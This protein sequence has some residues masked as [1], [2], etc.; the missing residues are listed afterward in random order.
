MGG[1]TTDQ[2]EI[3]PNWI[4]LKRSRM[5]EDGAEL[6]DELMRFRP[7]GM[8]ANAWAV[9]AGVGRAI[10][11]DMKRHGN[12]SRKTL[13]KLLAAAGSS[14]AEFEALRIGQPASVAATIE[15]GLA[16]PGRSWRP[17]PLKPVP[18]L[19]SHVVGEWGAAGR[20]I[21][22]HFIDR[23]R[24]VGQVDRPAALS[25]DAEAYAV[26]VAG[27]SMWPR[28]RAGRRLLVSPGAPVSVCDDVLV[29]LVVGKVLIKELVRRS[30]S[31]IELR[32]FNPN[33]TFAVD[34]GQVASVHK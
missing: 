2:T 10:W 9:N 1:G 32:Q 31:K 15:N 11:A 19:A 26:R 28:F 23:L 18:L 24:V 5:A 3:D 20:G 14:L 4:M 29:R 22:L 34:A 25:A 12:P 27:E 7:V 33:A 13:E 21:E 6:I 30:A 8:T 16:E 17:A